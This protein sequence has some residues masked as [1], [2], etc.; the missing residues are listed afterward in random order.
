[1]RVVNYNLETWMRLHASIQLPFVR[2]LARQLAAKL[3][4]VESLE[5]Q[6]EERNWIQRKLDLETACKDM[7]RE[8]ARLEALIQNQKAEFMR[9]KEEQQKHLQQAELWKQEK[10]AAKIRKFEDACQER[11]RKQREELRV[12]QEETARVMKQCQNLVESRQVQEQAL[13]K[14]QETLQ[15][16][17]QQCKELK[18]EAARFPENQV[19]KRTAEQKDN[20]KRRSISSDGTETPTSSNEERLALRQCKRI[21]TVAFT[22]HSQEESEADSE[23][24]SEELSPQEGSERKLEAARESTRVVPEA[25]KDASVVRGVQQ[26][27]KATRPYPQLLKV[28]NDKEPLSS[29]TLREPGVEELKIR[30]QEEWCHKQMLQS[31]LMTSE[32]KLQELA[33][34]EEQRQELM[35]RLQEEWCQRQILQ[36]QLMTSEHELQEL[37]AVCATVS[38]ECF[39]LKS[40]VLQL[41]KEL[42][43][44]REALEANHTNHADLNWFMEKAKGAIDLVSVA[45]QEL[46][47]PQRAPIFRNLLFAFHP[48]K[49][50]QKNEVAT[51]VFQH[52][53]Q[54]KQS[55]GTR[56]PPDD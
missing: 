49:N 26:I 30:L 45:L 40:E 47:A 18:L 4:G 25:A 21:A 3:D 2:H 52:L 28:F 6:E 11:I 27:E 5:A 44:E 34:A 54:W 13:R 17:Q 12:L 29:R 43:Q 31:Q 23:K 46:P 24:K 7:E 10:A 20:Q 15:I 50:L 9:L 1:M 39:T 8:R 14:Q 37:R 33:G 51:A 35:I 36:K 48:D 55:V 32:Q 22:P 19:E 42:A 16:L 38:G 53:Q 56:A 41:R